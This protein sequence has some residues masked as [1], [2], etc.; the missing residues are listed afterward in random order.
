MWFPMNA[1]KESFTDRRRTRS[2]WAIPYALDAL[3]SGYV[4]TI[5][6]NPRLDLPVGGTGKIYTLA[7][8]VVTN[9][10]KFPMF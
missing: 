5:T 3:P 4:I 8:C 7:N 6:F 1:N 2:H 9:A 10:C